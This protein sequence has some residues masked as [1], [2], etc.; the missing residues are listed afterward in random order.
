MKKMLVVVSLLMLV[1]ALSAMAEEPKPT[2]QPAQTATGT[3]FS[4]AEPPHHGAVDVVDITRI[5]CNVTEGSSE[6]PTGFYLMNK[7]NTV[8]KKGTKIHWELPAVAPAKGDYTFA[9]D[10]PVN[11]SV[12]VSSVLG[13]GVPAGS[14]CNVTV[15]SKPKM[16]SVKQPIA[17]KP[18][19]T[20]P[21]VPMLLP[22]VVQ[23]SPVEFP[24]D[25]LITNNRTTTIPKGKIIHW[26][27]PNT[28]IQGDYTLTEDL[29]PQKSMYMYEILGGGMSA[30]L[31]CNATVK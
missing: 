2:A 27:M 30:G 5:T 14:Q 17:V 1:C 7:G 31:K 22:C 15:L 20:V 23:G 13:P 9:A 10:L 8:V 16:L 19:G 6:F 18:A 21:A 28:S 11:G 26:S 3:G 4:P 24:N 29:L 12:H 25:L